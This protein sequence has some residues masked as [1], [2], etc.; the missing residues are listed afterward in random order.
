MTAWE[1]GCTCH[2]HSSRWVRSSGNE[3]TRSKFVAFQLYPMCTGNPEDKQRRSCKAGCCRRP[4]RGKFHRTEEEMVWV[5]SRTLHIGKWLHG[6]NFCKE[7]K[8]STWVADRSFGMNCL[9]D[10][11]WGKAV[12]KVWA[13]YQ[14]CA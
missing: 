6:G 1:Q 3:G 7:G 12:C 8:G 5:A 14:H 2:T 4:A 11:D 9:R 13:C 10:I